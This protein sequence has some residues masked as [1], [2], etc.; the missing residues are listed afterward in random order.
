MV[1]IVN[2]ILFFIIVQCLKIF[3]YMLRFIYKGKS[4]HS[5]L[6]RYKFSTGF[7]ELMSYKQSRR[8]NES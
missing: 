7:L 4:Y 6:K 8:K 5:S 2:F 3:M 1:F